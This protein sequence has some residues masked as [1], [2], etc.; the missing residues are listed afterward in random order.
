MGPL[1]TGPTT[2][3]AA[4]AEEFVA[5]KRLAEWA[6]KPGWAIS[7][8]TDPT[9]LGAIDLRVDVVN[10]VGE[11]GYSLAQPAW[12]HGYMTEAANAVVGEA[13]ARWSV[14]K[15]AASADIDNVGSWRVLEKLGMVREGL[16]RSHRVIHGSRRDW[17]HYGL[18]R[19]EWEA[20]L[21]V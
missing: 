2:L 3:R 11:L 6:D 8:V 19:E 1:P 10:A 15:I 18:L 4:H 17:V 16:S 21:P 12:N 7:L 20:A 14:A 5:A 9:V 13:F